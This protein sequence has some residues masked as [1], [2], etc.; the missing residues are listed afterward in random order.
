[1]A[2]LATHCPALA[3]PF[4]SACSG[5][6]GPLLLSATSLPWIGG[7]YRSTTTGFAANSVGLGFLG[8]QQ[9]NTPL[10]ALHPAGVPGCDLMV[11][12][13]HSVLVLPIAGIATFSL[14]VPDTVAIVGIEVFQQFV[15]VEFGGAGA[16]TSISGSNGVELT[17]GVF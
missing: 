2:T 11:S 17:L 13:D 6:G 7:S 15:Q 12:V 10:S 5:S 8:L 1:M 16:I 9:V 3:A 4:G 14:P